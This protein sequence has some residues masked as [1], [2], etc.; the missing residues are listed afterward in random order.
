MASATN[1]ETYFKSVQVRKI[2]LMSDDIITR[3]IN[4]MLQKKHPYPYLTRLL[5]YQQWCL[6]IFPDIKTSDVL[7][8]DFHETTFNDWIHGDIN[9]SRAFLTLDTLRYKNYILPINYNETEDI[10]T[11]TSTNNKP[12]WL[13]RKSGSNSDF[14]K[15]SDLIVIAGAKLGP[16]ETDP[17]EIHQYRMLYLHGV[18]WYPYDTELE[19]KLQNKIKLGHMITAKDIIW[20]FDRMGLNL[21]YWVC[22]YDMLNWFITFHGYEIQNIIKPHMVNQEELYKTTEI[23]IEP[24]K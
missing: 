14:I 24:A 7:K 11:E 12:T 20:N 10:L 1:D 4:K 16:T 5:D 9:W 18:G 2:T 6:T 23:D 8:S 21:P 22:L 3:P 15:N 17:I 13:I 19:H